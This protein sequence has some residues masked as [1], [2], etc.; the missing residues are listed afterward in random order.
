MKL[1]EIPKKFFRELEKAID[2]RKE[3]KGARAWACDGDF[4]RT[5]KI[6]GKFKLPW[7]DVRVLFLSHG[8]ACDCEIILTLQP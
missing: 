3:P 4:R 2:F 1:E 7:D 8:V 5:K 6:A